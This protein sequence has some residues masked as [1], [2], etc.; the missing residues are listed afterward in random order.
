[1]IEKIDGHTPLTKAQ[2]PKSEQKLGV[3]TI[4][5]ANDY[6]LDLD[7]RINSFKQQGYQSANTCSGSCNS[8]NSCASCHTFGGCPCCDTADARY[9]NRRG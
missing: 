7:V 9:C 1:M 4:T 6:D 2:S 5:T 8:C 3:H